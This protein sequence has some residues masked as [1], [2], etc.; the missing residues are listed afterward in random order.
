M[1][2]RPSDPQQL[3]LAHRAF[4]RITV[5][6]EE[7]FRE[8]EDRVITLGRSLRAS[9]VDRF[10]RIAEQERFNQRLVTL[11]DSLPVAVLVL[12]PL[13]RVVE[14]NEIARGWLGSPL[15]SEIWTSIRTRLGITEE[16]SQP[17]LVLPNGRWV[18]VTLR[19]LEDQ[20]NRLLVLTDVTPDGDELEASSAAA[21][22]E[23][24]QN[25]KSKHVDLED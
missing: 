15:I 10:R 22:R 20:T 21:W 3:E 17:L 12:D 16:G 13:D 4:S 7:T 11:F 8:L 14:A 6:L 19:N 1:S 23:G 25:K 18:H 5:Y 2:D 24:L 9:R